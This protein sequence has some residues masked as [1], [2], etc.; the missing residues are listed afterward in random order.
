MPFVIIFLLSWYRRWRRRRILVQPFPPEWIGI[1]EHN[2]AHYR[3]LSSGEQQTLHRLVQFFV[4]EKYWEGCRGLQMTDE[5][6]ITIA[7]QACLMLLGFDG[8]CFDRLLT[9]LVYPDEYVV[10]E[11]S[12]EP[13]GVVTESR[14]PRLGEAWHTGPVVLSWKDARRDARH[15]QRGHNVILHEFAHVLDMQDQVFDGTPPLENR[16]AYR[17]WQDVMTSE[18]KQ[19]LRQIEAARPTF[20]DG[21]GATNEAEFFAVA[22]E[23]FFCRPESMAARSPRLYD[24]LKNFYRQDPARRVAGG[25]G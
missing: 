1:L 11:T 6:K 3:Q 4:A 17:T 2:V 18:Y 20:L 15:P 16:D 19:L 10:Q 9:V 5:I 8:E 7:G 22:T 13:S 21:Y 25:D 14:S 23:S 12:Y 24:L